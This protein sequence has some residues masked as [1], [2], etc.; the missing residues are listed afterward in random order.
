MAD[1]SAR[2]LKTI[3]AEREANRTKGMAKSRR[4]FG[5]MGAKIHFH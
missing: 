1:K 5:Q 4:E 2:A 3:A